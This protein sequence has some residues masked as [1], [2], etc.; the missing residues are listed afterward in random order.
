[1][2]QLAITAIVSIVCS[3]GVSYATRP[4]PSV[5]QET[6]IQR[7]EKRLSRIASIVGLVFGEA[8]E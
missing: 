1:M 6:R 2:K 7:I 4:V 3:C 5:S 8:G